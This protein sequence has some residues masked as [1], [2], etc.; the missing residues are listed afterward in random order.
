M[1]YEGFICGHS[2]SYENPYPLHSK[3]FL[4]ATFYGVRGV[5]ML[6]PP[7]ISREDFLRGM[8]KL[9]KGCVNP[10]I[11]LEVYDDFQKEI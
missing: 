10:Q 5:L 11:V 2:V 6:L 4:P 3:S 7:S 8:M 1:K 9:T